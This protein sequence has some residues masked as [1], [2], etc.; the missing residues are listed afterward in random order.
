M[1]MVTL[2]TRSAQ[3]F[4]GVRGAMVRGVKLLG[5]GWSSDSATVYVHGALPM[6]Q[7]AGVPST[8]CVLA[9]GA[10]DGVLRGAVG[11]AGGGPTIVSAAGFYG[12]WPAGRAS[13]WT[14]GQGWGRDEVA[15][16]LL[17]G[18]R[19]DEL[20]VS[21]D[22]VSYQEFEL[23]RQVVGAMYGGEECWQLVDELRGVVGELPDLIKRIV[24][25]PGRGREQAPSA[26]EVIEAARKLERR[27]TREVERYAMALIDEV[28]W[29][30]GGWLAWLGVAQ[31]SGV[32][33]TEPAPARASREARGASRREQEQAP[34]AGQ[35]AP[36]VVI[37]GG[38][39]A[40]PRSKRRV[41]QAM[42]FGGFLGYLPVYAYLWWVGAA[43][44][45]AGLFWFLM[46]SVGP[47]CG[48]IAYRLFA[49]RLY[50]L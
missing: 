32:A 44:I 48:I 41:Y 8:G 27:S 26:R 39:I 50:G 45:D 13:R 12:A 37:Q 25:E 20:L 23:R 1:A 9:W 28:K 34:R 22:L 36:L 19:V 24:N 10:S 18:Q 11:W 38:Q 35:G 21:E 30:K 31:M 43:A 6:E 42:I 3:V 33:Q 49:R 5:A 40:R 14:G 17:K 16:G 2:A 47:L 29:L 15:L 46:L 7:V 4:D